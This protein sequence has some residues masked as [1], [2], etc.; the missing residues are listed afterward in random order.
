MSTHVLKFSIVILV[1][2]LFYSVYFMTSLI[3]DFSVVMLSV[4]V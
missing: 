2:I 3:C 4:T 1:D